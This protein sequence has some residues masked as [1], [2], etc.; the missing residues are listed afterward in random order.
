[1]GHSGLQSAALEAIQA[2]GSFTLVIS[3][4]SMIKALA[5]L[6]ADPNAS[7]FSKWHVAW[8]DE[9]NV[10]LSNP[11]SNFKV[12]SPVEISND[13]EICVIYQSLCYKFTIL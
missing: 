3:G 11:D 13:F 8:A 7:D 9:R 6:A 2:K 4:G 12:Y 5:Q 1:M 10:S